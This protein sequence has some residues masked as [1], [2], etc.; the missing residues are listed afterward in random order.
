M[1]HQIDSYIKNLV[2]YVFKGLTV[3]EVNLWASYSCGVGAKGLCITLE[4]VLNLHQDYVA[5]GELDF[6]LAYKLSQDH[7]ETFFSKV[8]A[9]GGFN[10]NPN[11]VH[12]CAAYKKLLIHNQIRPSLHGNCE[13]DKDCEI[14]WVSSDQQ[15]SQCT[16]ETGPVEESPMEID[17]LPDLP[18]EVNHIVIYIAGFVERRIL[19][20]MR[21]DICPKQI[22]NCEAVHGD[23]IQAKTTIKLHYPREDTHKLCQTLEKILRKTEIS[24]HTYTR[25]SQTFFSTV[26]IN[27][28]FKT[29]EFGHTNSCG[30]QFVMNKL[31]DTFLCVRLKE[32]E[33]RMKPRNVRGKFKR[34]LNLMGQ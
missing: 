9:M 6:L 33:K 14:L 29:V 7:L 8:R 1:V 24:T 3:K 5:T 18:E 32:I 21:C 30:K 17:D 27:D 26:D 23:L 22:Y 15:S 2:L 16:E 11:V 4:S 31:V 19:Q 10:P 34:M 20:K 28:Y 13:E 12:F 25:I